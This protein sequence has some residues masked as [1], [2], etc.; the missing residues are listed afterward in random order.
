MEGI[1]LRGGEIEPP[2]HLLKLYIFQSLEVLG[3]AEQEPSLRGGAP[4][5]FRTVT[6]MEG[7]Q[8][9]GVSQERHSRLT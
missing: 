2:A 3:V 5:D 1:H 6:G 4:D 7:R 8:P 9:L